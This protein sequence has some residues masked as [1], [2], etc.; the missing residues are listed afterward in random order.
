[1]PAEKVQEIFEGFTPRHMESLPLGGVSVAQG[2]AVAPHF[3]F[4]LF[5][6][7]VQHH[8]I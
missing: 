3:V 7:P 5:A 1:M 4:E 2:A 8:Q 6:G